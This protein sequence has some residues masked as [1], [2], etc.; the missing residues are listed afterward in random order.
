MPGML[1]TI[2][3]VG[4]CDV[5]VPGLLHA[6]GDPVFV[7]DSYRRLIQSHAEVVAGCP[8]SLFDGALADER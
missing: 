2:L 7:W 6:T 4:L 8:A 1:D 3:N 5:T